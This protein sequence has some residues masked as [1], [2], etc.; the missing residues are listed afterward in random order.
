[1]RLLGADPEAIRD[2][3]F[4]LHNP[5]PAQI[6]AAQEWAPSP[7]RER[8]LE[9]ILS[10]RWE[11]FIKDIPFTKHRDVYQWITRKLNQ[12]RW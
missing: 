6:L 2:R 12:P 7:I 1:M 11:P 4:Y 8:P 3:V 10:Q 5:E 9:D